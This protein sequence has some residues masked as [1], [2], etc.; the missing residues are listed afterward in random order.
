MTAP[1]EL[2]WTETR[3]WIGRNLLLKPREGVEPVDA[4]TIRR[5]LEV[6]EFDCPLHYDDEVARRHGYKGIIA[7]LHMVQ[8]YQ[9]SAIWEPGQASVW[10]SDER[11][12]TVSGTGQHGEMLRVPAPAQP[13]FVTDL[14]VDFFQPLYIGDRVTQVEHRLLEVNPRKTRV[15]DGAFLTYESLYVNQRGERVARQRS[16]GY[17]FIPNP[18]S[19]P[20][21][22]DSSESS[23]LGNALAHG[24]PW[25]P[26]DWS[27]QRYWEDMSEAGEV[28]EVR[29]PL[30]LQRL[31][32]AAGANRDFN[33]VHHNATVA[34]RGGAPDAYAMNY[35]HHGMWERAV[36]EFIGL[37]G[38]IKRVGPFRMRIFAV[39]GDTL[40]V[41][42]RVTKKY[43]DGD[44]NLLELEMESVSAKTGHITVG[45][46]PVVVA[47]P[48][49]GAR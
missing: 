15:G 4:L 45:P 21:G 20:V 39:V 34:Q 24:K 18:Q 47:L 5:E 23:S 33:A 27:V 6:L 35:F 13:G 25:K 43:Q 19:Q 48:S 36:R 3:K 16:T 7:P 2:D 26:V 30:T 10:S 49:R 1:A 37:D 17:S 29:Y 11:D 14:Q 31:V 38:A 12:F 40:V 42:G 28:P 41:R 9:V 44:S 22:G 8:T 46:G 32:M